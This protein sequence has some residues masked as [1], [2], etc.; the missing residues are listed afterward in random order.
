MSVDDDASATPSVEKQLPSSHK[1]DIEMMSEIRK[2][3]L[4]VMQELAAHELPSKLYI[5][6][7]KHR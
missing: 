2:M 5:A 4:T 3:R 7:I 1:L 6:K